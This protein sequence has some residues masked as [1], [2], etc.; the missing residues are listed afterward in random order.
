MLKTLINQH[1]LTT[2]LMNK[3]IIFEIIRK[4]NY[5]I[6]LFIFN[7]FTVFVTYFYDLNKKIK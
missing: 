5:L 2:L 4:F 3:K 7:F 1:I 6:W